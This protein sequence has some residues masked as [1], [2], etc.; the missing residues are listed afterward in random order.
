M[1]ARVAIALVSLLLL[2]LA[3]LA[4]VRYMGHDE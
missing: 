4:G 2:V 1:N 3:A